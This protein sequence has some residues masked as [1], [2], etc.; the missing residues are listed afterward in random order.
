MLESLGTPERERL[1]VIPVIIARTRF[2]RSTS[3]MMM[4][5]ATWRPT[6][7]R[8][9]HRLMPS[10]HSFAAIPMR[11]RSNSSTGTGLLCSCFAARTCCFNPIINWTTRCARAVSRLGHLKTP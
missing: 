6:M 9:V 10:L 1:R 11:S 2:F 7:A 8:S 5:A 4:T 3:D